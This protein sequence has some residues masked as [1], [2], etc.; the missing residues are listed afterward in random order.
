MEKE[1]YTTAEFKEVDEE[2]KNL[3]VDP[4]T[5]P[6]LHRHELMVKESDEIIKSIEEEL[7]VDTE[8]GLRNQADLT[9]NKALKHDIDKL[10]SSKDYFE[11]SSKQLSQLF[12]IG[13][14]KRK[15]Y[16]ANLISF[17]S[18][19][20]KTCKLPL[21]LDISFLALIYPMMIFSFAVIPWKGNPL[22][23]TLGLSNVIAWVG[24]LIL[25]IYGI[26]TW[27]KK[28]LSYLLINVKIDT[29]PLSSVSSP[30]PYGAKLKVLEAK[31]T[32]IFKDFVFATPE[33]DIEGKNHLIDLKKNFPPIDPAILGVTED[34]R[35]YMIVYWD[36][37]KDVERIIK[38]I[39][40]F[41]KYKLGKA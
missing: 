33:F 14:L 1:H 30:I 20:S 15:C 29:R 7:N 18:G 23:I 5:L 35:M 39:K 19:V 25:L 12:Q 10:T 36:L 32:G 31:K 4:S 37:D 24:M 11:I 17:W 40:D 6:S 26:I 27:D 28:E 34:K 2:E 38:N 13:A 3:P 16:W 41:K 9:A 8:L 21:F 22:A